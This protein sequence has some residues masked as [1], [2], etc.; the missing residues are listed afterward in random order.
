MTK[1]DD[2]LNNV[3]VTDYQNKEMLLLASE[4]FD[5]GPS[6]MLESKMLESK[7]S[8]FGVDSKKRPQ[9]E[10]SKSMHLQPTKKNIM[11]NSQGMDQSDSDIS[12]KEGSVR[13]LSNN[14]R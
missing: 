1:D 8:G 10:V 11:A 12:R 2:K 3:K 5:I 7:T 9:H 4:I 13:S 14:S 6:M